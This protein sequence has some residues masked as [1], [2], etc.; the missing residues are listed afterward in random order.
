MVKKKTQ[1][2]SDELS[3]KDLID[4][5]NRQDNICNNNNIKIIIKNTIDHKFIEAA[6]KIYPDIFEKIDI[7]HKYL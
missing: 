2:N 5:N 1:L 3:V 6:K 7:Q 4:N